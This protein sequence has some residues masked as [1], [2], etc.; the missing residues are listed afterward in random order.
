MRL[1]LFHR[2]R[3]HK[4]L[5]PVT[6]FI[7]NADCIVS[8]TSPRGSTPSIRSELLTIP[9]ERSST[10]TPSERPTVII[11]DDINR[12]LQYLHGPENDRQRD[13]QGVHN[14][15]GEIQ[16]ELRDLAD[17]IHEKEPPA[18]PLQF[19]SSSRISPLVGKASYLD[20]LTE[21]LIILKFFL[22]RLARQ[23]RNLF[24]LR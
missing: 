13:S 8:M 17:Y 12:L 4:F 7:I 11:T 2:F 1:T 23:A 16:N 20:H 15:L 10:E 21:H 19:S 22:P 9:S 18:T 5:C 14:H 6:I 24:R 3:Q